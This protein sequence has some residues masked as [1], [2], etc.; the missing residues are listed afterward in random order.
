MERWHQPRPSLREFRPGQLT[1]GQTC[2]R[3]VPDVTTTVIP[4]NATEAQSPAH[5]NPVK[6]RN[7]R[8]AEW[9]RFCL[10]TDESVDKLSPQ[11]T[12]NIE[13]AYQDF[14]KIL[15][16]AA[17]QCIPRGR[18]KNNVACKECET[19]YRS[20]TRAPVG[21]DYNRATSSLLS[22]LGQ[23]KQE[24]REEAVNSIVFLHSSRMTWRTIKK[25]IGRSGRS[26]RQ[27]PVSEN[28]ITSQLVKSGAH[29][30]GDRESTRLVNKKLTDL[31]KI[32]T[33]E[34]HS[35]SGPFRPVL[36]ALILCRELT[37]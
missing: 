28:S 6:R 2:S 21:T 1:A 33:P 27:C 10:L 32:P 25:L 22:G 37:A 19:L 12:S 15:L 11:D 36:P 31:W 20:F 26:F 29:K 16:S 4:H 14:C 7:F 3:K 8:K 35:I 9:K 5:S 30:T 13:R 24:R 18:R 23:K 17:K 34:G